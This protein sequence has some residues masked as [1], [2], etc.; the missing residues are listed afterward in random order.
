MKI[1]KGRSIYFT[2]RRGDVHSPAL[3]DMEYALSWRIDLFKKKK[4]E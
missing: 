1:G 3:S 2:Y 4:E